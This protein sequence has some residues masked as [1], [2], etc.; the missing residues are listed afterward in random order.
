MY[1]QFLLI[2]NLDLQAEIYVLNGLMNNTCAEDVDI[3]HDMVNKRPPRSKHLLTIDCTLLEVSL[4]D[5]TARLEEELAFPS[6]LILELSSDTHEMFPF[7]IVQHN[8]V[9]ARFDRLICLSFRTHFH[10]KQ[11]AK[12]AH[13]AG[14]LD[15]S[16]D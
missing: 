15:C 14:L 3:Y 16:G 13:C 1:I 5:V 6:P 7:H 2:R 9:S 12:A 11:Q 10:I 4:G 8:D